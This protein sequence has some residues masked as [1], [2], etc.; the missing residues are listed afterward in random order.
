MPN[1]NN[2]IYNL[3]FLDEMASKKTL[4]HNINPV[5]K[6]LVTLLYSVIVISFGK[7]DISG[8]VP[9]ISYPI[10][11]FILSDIPYLPVFK[12]VLVAL[13]FVSGVGILNPIFDTR[14]Y[15]EVLGLGVS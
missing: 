8:L 10:I 11:I 15:I 5:V 7:Y 1:I 6:L 13:P 3:R 14:I 12:R 4:V 2:S 9:F